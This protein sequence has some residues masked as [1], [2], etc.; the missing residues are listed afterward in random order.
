MIKKALNGEKLT[1]YGSGKYIRDYI[2][3]DDVVE[4]LMMLAIVKTDEVIFNI[5][6][7]VGYSLNEI[8][9]KIKNVA[10]SKIEC[11]YENARDDDITTS[12]LCVERI[13]ETID[14]IP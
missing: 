6:S 3:I 4:Q 10:G 1:I 12:I 13:K 11:I 7:G 9:Y 14:N 2:Y 5:G 8:I